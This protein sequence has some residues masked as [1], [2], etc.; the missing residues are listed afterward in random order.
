MINHFYFLLQK[1]YLRFISCKHMTKLKI[2]KSIFQVLIG[3]IIVLISGV[4]IGFLVPKALGEYNYG[5]YKTYT[6]YLTY[7]GMMHFGFIEGVYLKYSGKMYDEIDYRELR[8]LTIILFSIDTIVV[9]STI[10]ISLVFLQNEYKI[11]FLLLALTIIPNHF[12][13]YLRTIS[14]VTMRFKEF[15][16]LNIIQSIFQILSCLIIFFLWS[17]TSSYQSP[18]LFIILV[19]ISYII[20]LLI[21]IVNYRKI[22]FGKIYKLKEVKSLC[23][24]I[25]FNGSILLISNTIVTLILNLDRQFVNVLFDYNTYGSYSFAY[26]IL[27]LFTTI[28]STISVVVFPMMKTTSPKT[29]EK[30]YIE[31]SSLLLMLLFFCIIG[32]FP[33]AYIVETFLQDY[34]DSIIIFKIII[35]AISFSSSISILMHNYF[36]VF[37]K[38]K[39]YFFICFCILI[40][41]FC[42]NFIAYKISY[43]TYPISIASVICLFIWYVVCDRYLLS[44][45]KLKNMKN[46]IY[47]LIMIAVFY[48]IVFLIPNILVQLVTYIFLF[49]TISIGFYHKTIANYIKLQKEKK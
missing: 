32:F 44:K 49:L 45:M 6:L 23:K 11:I 29:L 24:E 13:G 28:I 3:Q 48:L 42:A 25:F 47:I 9:T 17:Y 35:P 39:Q 37:G 14:Q 34:M 10:F 41:S 18:Y 8:T 36:K 27:S 21:Y 46:M 22:L 7:F 20:V 5:I 33:I 38:H 1:L 12:L 15:S 43:H 40:L 19:I 4:L 30:H 26:S 31:F 16:I 2:N